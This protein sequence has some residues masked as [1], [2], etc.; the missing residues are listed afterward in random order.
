MFSSDPA[1]PL[2]SIS[3]V[4]F[5]RRLTEARQLLLSQHFGEALA[6]YAQLTRQCPGE[7]ILWFE[8]GNAASSLHDRELA[9]RAWRKALE[10]APANAELIGLI[11]H[12]YQGAR[13]PE[14]AR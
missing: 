11:G 9:D 5:Q 12:Q 6:S 7:A 2:Q 13:N 8:Y 10:L 3:T 14:R 1:A 4:E